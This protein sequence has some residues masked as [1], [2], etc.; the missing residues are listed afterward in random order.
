[1]NSEVQLGEIVYAKAGRDRGSYFVV[2]A[3]EDIEYVRICDG[4]HRKVEKSK[5]KKVKH[6]RLKVG[7]SEFINEK[8]LKN[9]K[10]TNRQIRNELESYNDSILTA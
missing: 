3:I 8:L 6:L 4:K 2:I 5:K 9:D 1:M 10:I 7:F